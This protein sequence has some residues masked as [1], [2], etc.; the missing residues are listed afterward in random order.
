LPN[1]IWSVDIRLVS[2]EHD[3]GKAFLLIDWKSVGLTFS[4][5]KY[6]N[7]PCLVEV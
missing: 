4:C 7:I 2:A 3:V 5:K 1:G 6:K